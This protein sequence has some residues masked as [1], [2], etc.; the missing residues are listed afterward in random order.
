MK[1]GKRLGT[2]LLAH[3]FKPFFAAY[4]LLLEKTTK[5]IVNKT[6]IVGKTK[7]LI[8]KI[9][10]VLLLFLLLAILKILKFKLLFQTYYNI[11]RKLE[12]IIRN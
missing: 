2:T 8:E 3:N 10:N 1:K 6:K 7:S 5:P 11:F 12:N 9:A 4:K